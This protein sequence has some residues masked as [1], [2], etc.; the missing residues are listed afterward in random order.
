MLSID[1]AKYFN[2]DQYLTKC[3]Q[4]VHA[5]DQIPKSLKVGQFYICNTETSNDQGKHWFV[6][7]RPQK[8][9]LECFDSLGTSSNDTNQLAKHLKFRGINKIKFNSTKL[10]AD[11]T[12]SCGYHCI[13]F[14]YQRLYN[15]DLQY[16]ELL[17][18]V[19]SP[20]DQQA[21]ERI[22]TDFI[23]ELLANLT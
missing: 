23:N 1:F 6:V 9:I 16:K 14:V 5:F 21:N 15:N 4:G 3:F 20:T 11:G 10:Q 12:E 18:E 7:C 8:S 22:V 17:N 13:Y 2:C 19:Y